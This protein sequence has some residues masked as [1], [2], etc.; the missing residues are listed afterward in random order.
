MCLAEF[1]GRYTLDA[2]SERDG[3]IVVVASFF[4]GCSWTTHNR[5]DPQFQ[6]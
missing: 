1:V 5:C 3:G 4:G 6:S 2:N